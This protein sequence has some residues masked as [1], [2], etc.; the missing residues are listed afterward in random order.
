MSILV[1]DAKYTISSA[2]HDL[3]Y[4]AL[5]E[6]LSDGYTVLGGSLYAVSHI[7]HFHNVRLNPQTLSVLND[8]THQLGLKVRDKRTD[9]IFRLRAFIASQILGT[10]VFG[11]I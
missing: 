10:I 7:Y 9:R 6:V 2:Q 3:L 4:I 5:L 8:T 1:S 11:F